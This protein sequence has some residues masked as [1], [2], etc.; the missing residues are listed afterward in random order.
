MGNYA[1]YLPR[2]PSTALN[3][4]LLPRP[5]FGSIWPERP[6][7]SSSYH[8]C[9]IQETLHQTNLSQGVLAG[10]KTE[11]IPNQRLGS[12]WQIAK[13][14]KHVSSFQHCKVDNISVVFP[15]RESE[16]SLQGVNISCRWP[17]NYSFLV[18]C[19]EN[20]LF[21]TIENISVDHEHFFLVDCK[22][23]GQ[24]NVQWEHSWN[25]KNHLDGCIVIVIESFSTWRHFCCAISFKSQGLGG[26]TPSGRIRWEA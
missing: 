17:W 14:I 12:I 10:K 11:S 22:R 19:N 7:S 20:I 23:F 21:L 8:L 9:W 5:Y 1:V 6:L 16:E 26:W 2:H 24:I 3:N 4:V 18:D 13:L 25:C 15:A